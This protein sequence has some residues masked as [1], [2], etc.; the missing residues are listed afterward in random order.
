MRRAITGF[1]QDDEGHWAALLECGHGQH[2]RHDPP[3]TDRPAVLTAEG[4][5]GL[6]GH[7][8]TCRLC[9]QGPSSRS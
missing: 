8:L 2:L 4:R 6:V 3:L 7:T 9:M 1:T 5:M